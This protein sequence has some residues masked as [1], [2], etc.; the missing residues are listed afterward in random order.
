MCNKVCNNLTKIKE[1]SVCNRRSEIITL[2]II[3]ST[4][5]LCTFFSLQKSHGMK[6][7]VLSFRDGT[8]LNTLVHN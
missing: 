4:N 7:D 1:V 5:I 6:T 2:E 8:C 3:F